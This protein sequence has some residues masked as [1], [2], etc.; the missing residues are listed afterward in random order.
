MEQCQCE[1]GASPVICNA[2][3]GY[4]FCSLQCSTA[5]NVRR[6]VLGHFP[7]EEIHAAKNVLWE[8]GLISAELINRR[9]GTTKTKEE[10]E[11]DDIIDALVELDKDT[12]SFAI[13]VP[14]TQLLRLP[15]LKPEDMHAVQVVEKIKDIEEL[16][17]AL[18]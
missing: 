2:V 1:G 10:F 5:A 15:R 14:A 11:A 7:P 12:T 4:M 13:H 8:S 9:G 6:V 16:V 17:N 3:L 18:L